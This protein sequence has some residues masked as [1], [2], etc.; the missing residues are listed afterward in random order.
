MPSAL[1]ERLLAFSG[2]GDAGHH[3]VAIDIDE[4]AAGIAFEAA[5]AGV[6]GA[7]IGQLHHEEAF[8]AH[9]EV[10]GLSRSG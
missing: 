5:V 3:L 10:E 4:Q 7:A 9:G 1:I 8:A 2:N 6:A